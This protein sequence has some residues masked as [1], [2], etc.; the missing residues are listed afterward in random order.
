M[1]STGQN[2]QSVHNE[3][4]SISAQVKAALFKDCDQQITELQNVVTN[5]KLKMSDEEQA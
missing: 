3:K 4:R 5:S 1:S 2:K